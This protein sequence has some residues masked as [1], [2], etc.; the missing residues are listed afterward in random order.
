MKL[1]RK[2]L[3]ATVRFKLKFSEVNTQPC[4]S[5]STWLIIWITDFV[6]R[7]YEVLRQTLG[8]QTKFHS[9]HHVV[10]I[11]NIKKHVGENSLA[12]ILSYVKL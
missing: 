1:A 11:Y 2:K 12:L 8:S 6:H 4:L 7:S 3:R 9:I 10:D 5:G